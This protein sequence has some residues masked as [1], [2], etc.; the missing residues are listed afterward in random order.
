MKPPTIYCR[1]KHG[2]GDAVQFTIVARHLKHYFPDHH[3]IVESP[4][5]RQNLYYG[6]ADESI[7]LSYPYKPWGYAQSHYI[8]WPHP[9]HIHTAWPSTKPTETL[10]EV[11]GLE[12]I[13]E[14]YHYHCHIT[15]EANSKADK[16]VDSLPPSK[17]IVAIHYE[18]VSIPEKKNLDVGTVAKVIERVLNAGYLPLIMDFEGQSKLVDGCQVFRPTLADVGSRDAA[19]G[20]YLDVSTVAALLERCALGVF[21][22]SGPGHLAGATTLPTLMVWTKLHP[23]ICY[24]LAPNVTHLVPWPLRHICTGTPDCWHTY[25]CGCEFVDEATDYFEQ[26]YSH[27]YYSN[28]D[29]ELPGLIDEVLSE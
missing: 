19:K 27:H 3:L 13:P 29:S 22:D 2:I 4:L 14:L 20:L 26:N 25:G 28:L 23:I 12:P 7:V 9:S 17:G 15:D 5:G 16:F 1:L 10:V 8:Q 21:I 18:G 24:D 11:M 6:I